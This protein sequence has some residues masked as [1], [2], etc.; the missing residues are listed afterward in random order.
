MRLTKCDILVGVNALPI[1]N[2]KFLVKLRCFNFTCII[3]AVD[4]YSDFFYVGLGVR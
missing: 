2:E 3:K 1:S 4:F